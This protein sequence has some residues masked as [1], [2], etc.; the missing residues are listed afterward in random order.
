MMRA[1]LFSPQVLLLDE[2][3]SALDPIVRLE[4]AREPRRLANADTGRVLLWVTHDIE[5][6]RAHA[7]TITIVRDGAAHGPHGVDVAMRTDSYLMR[8]DALL[9]RA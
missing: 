5:E 7:D 2:P 9:R 1:L 3:F 4:L 6:A 8:Y